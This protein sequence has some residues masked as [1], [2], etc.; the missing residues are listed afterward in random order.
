MAE[1][2]CKLC[3]VI[4]GETWDSSLVLEKT[5]AFSVFPG[6]GAFLEGYL[7]IVP[8]AHVNSVS[9]L[10]SDEQGEF[11]LLLRKWEKILTAKYGKNIVAVEAGTDRNSKGKHAHSVVHAHVHLFP[12]DMPAV[13]VFQQQGCPLREIKKTDLQSFNGRVYFLVCEKGKFYV[14]DDPESLAT[15]PSQFHRKVVADFVRKGE[16]YDWRKFPYIDEMI[17][18][19]EGLM[20]IQTPY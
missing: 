7:M 9:L 5:K 12:V 15:L 14:N 1:E 16:V 8:N 19:Y 4:N 20:N 17:R 10:D 18:T 2:I 13:D 11:F 6:T 3:Q